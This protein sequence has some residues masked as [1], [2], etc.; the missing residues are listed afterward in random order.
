MKSNSRI[1]QSVICERNAA[2]SGAVSC[3][4]D[5][6]IFATVFEY[7]VFEKSQRKVGESRRLKNKLESLFLTVLVRSLTFEEN[8]V[9]LV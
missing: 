9:A 1:R 3:S 4:V 8:K 2:S 5:F 6:A 7:A